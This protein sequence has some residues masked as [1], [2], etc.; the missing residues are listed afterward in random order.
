[1]HLSQ[2]RATAIWDGWIHN[3]FSVPPYSASE[4]YG[5][6]G[7]QVYTEGHARAARNLLYLEPHKP[8]CYSAH[9]VVE[10]LEFCPKGICCYVAFSKPHCRKLLLTFRCF[11]SHVPKE[12]LRFQV[13]KGNNINP[14]HRYIRIIYNIQIF[15]LSFEV[16]P[17]LHTRCRCRSL[18]LLLITLNYTHSHTHNGQD[19][20]GRGIGPLQRRS[21]RCLTTH[22]THKKQPCSRRNSNP[23][24]QPNERPQT[25]PL[26][27]RGRQSRLFSSFWSLFQ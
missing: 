20:C 2:R 14:F 7:S 13:M 1:M 24:S 11:C 10:A 27:P 8:I 25:Y 17:L 15:F 23:Q 19:F 22:N 21:D 26:R 6:P 9:P 12:Q 3:S 4:L 18:L 16:W 5:D